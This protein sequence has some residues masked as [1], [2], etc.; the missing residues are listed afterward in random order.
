MPKRVATKKRSA[1]KQ[2]ST[3]V[4]RQTEP[5]KGSLVWSLV[6]LDVESTLL[7]PADSANAAASVAQLV[8]RARQYQKRARYAVQSCIGVPAKG[9]GA[10]SF[11]FLRVTRLA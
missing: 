10:A 3:P 4:R 6:N 1:I 9:V 8:I 11:R 7:F 2:A 5:R